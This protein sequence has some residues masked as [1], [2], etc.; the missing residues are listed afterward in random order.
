[1]YDG[2]AKR[3]KRYA[4]GKDPR[5]LRIARLFHDAQSP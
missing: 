5:Q 3:M 2:F 1:M 4:W